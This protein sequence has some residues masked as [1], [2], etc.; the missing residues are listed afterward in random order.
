MTV[1]SGML[2][3]CACFIPVTSEM[4]EK[5]LKPLVV[6]T[7]T[8]TNWTLPP[9]KSRKVPE[10]TFT[11]L[12]LGCKTWLL[13]LNKAKAFCHTGIYQCLKDMDMTTMEHYYKTGTYSR[14]SYILKSFLKVVR[15][16]DRSFIK[17]ESFS[18]RFYMHFSADYG[19]YSHFTS[20]FIASK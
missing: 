12:H 20:I 10:F 14:K 13:F 7:S 17:Q 19:G 4:L 11:R 2:F 18:E 15:S 3:C 9:L 5:D 16:S 6:T 1:M 8:G